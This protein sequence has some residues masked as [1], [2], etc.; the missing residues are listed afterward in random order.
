MPDSG[1]AIGGV[2]EKRKGEHVDIVINQD[3]NARA[4]SWDD[5][6]LIHE[7]LPE[8]D[9]DE[10]STET[11]F[12]GKK[13][14]APIVISGMTG[15]FERALEINRHLAEAASELQIPMGVGS[16]RAAL[17]K[18][19]LAGTYRVI[20]DY[21]IPL[22]IANIGAPQLV[23]QG[24]RRAYGVDDAKSAMEMIDGHLLAV[25]LNYLQEVVQPEGDR[26]ATGVLKAIRTIAKQMPVMAKETGAGIS[27][28]VAARLKNAGVRAIDVG[29][30]GGT[31]WSAVES[32]RADRK[33]D[34][35]GMRLGRTFW[36]WGIPTPVSIVQADV[37]LP[38]VATGGVRHGLDVGRAICLG[39][40]AAGLAGAIIRP[41][42][43]SR[44]AVLDELRSIIH[45]LKIVMFL[46]ASRNLRRLAEREYVISGVSEEWLAHG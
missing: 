20:A 5:I 10:I 32:Y 19:E 17:E 37:G 41:A 40:S 7:S 3:V 11:R 8:L 16:Q 29:G 30:L 34:L 9:F 6:T 44:K 28:P 26:R 14:S 21:D 46:T 38:I 43:E 22:R 25:H 24:D 36:N 35:L 12:L 33:G 39:A 45:E 13:I 15:G 18:K 27:A 42:S 23:R 2:T 31:S 1:D 4:N